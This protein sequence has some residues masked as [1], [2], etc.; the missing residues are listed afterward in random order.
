MFD[1]GG[2]W[3]KLEG[4]TAAKVVDRGACGERPVGLKLPLLL[5]AESV[6]RSITNIVINDRLHNIAMICRSLIRCS[7]LG[8]HAF[9]SSRYP[10]SFVYILQEHN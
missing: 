2:V 9:R 1:V 7:G 8:R 5:L 4:S 6:Q 10:A 3:E